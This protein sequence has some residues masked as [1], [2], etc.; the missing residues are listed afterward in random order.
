MSTVKWHAGPMTGLDTETTGTSPHNDN[1]VTAAVVHVVPGEPTRSIQ[2]LIHPGH[3]IP[4]EA[5]EV[6]GWSTERLEATLDGAEACRIVDEQRAP[7][8]RE[9]ALFEVAAQVATTIS[10]GRPLIA[11]NAAF[12]LTL[13]ESELVRA[14]IDTISSRPMG[15]RGVVD[16]MVIEKQYDPFRKVKGGCRGGK[17]ACGGC[18]VEDKKLGSL[19]THYQVRLDEAHDA[20]A[21]ALAALRL[22]WRLAHV[23]PEIG[24]LRLET[25]HAHQVGWRREQMDS[26]RR[27]FERSGIEHDG[28]DP[29]WP[30][31][32]QVVE[33]ASPQG[34]LL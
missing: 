16:P 17:Y 2:W 13:L 24:R 5:A 1:I 19:C 34:A 11:A 28:C 20:T 10:A 21:D 30:L 18:G 29:S 26:L 8:T 12:D 14:G 22:A 4:A 31:L 6:H 3:E 33:T 9:A 15:I 32:R 23:W 7:L 25:L 27:Y